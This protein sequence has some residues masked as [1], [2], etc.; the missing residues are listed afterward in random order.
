MSLCVWFGFSEEKLDPWPPR[1]E[2]SEYFIMLLFLFD[3]SE[4]KFQAYIMCVDRNVQCKDH[5]DIDFSTLTQLYI[6]ITLSSIL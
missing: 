2:I 4:Y 5:K 6:I 1:K 3:P